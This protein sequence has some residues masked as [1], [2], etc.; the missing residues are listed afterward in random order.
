LLVVIAI[1]G[2]L[3]ALL[4]PAVQAAREAARRMSCSNNLKQLALAL[5]NYHDTFKQMPPRAIGPHRWTNATTPQANTGT[6]ELGMN[7]GTLSWT[8][9]T[10]P[11]I[12]GQSANDAITSAV[13][14]AGGQ[15]FTGPLANG[16]NPSAANMARTAAVFAKVTV[17][18]TSNFEFA[19]F[20]CPSGPR[21]TQVNA[22]GNNP[23]GYLVNNTGGPLGRLSYKACIGGNSTGTQANNNNNTCRNA[24]NQNCDG[25][26]SY[27]R[28]ANFADMTDGTSNV[29]AIGEVAM[30]FTQP[31]RFIGSIA[32]NDLNRGGV[33]NGLRDPCQGRYNLT[34]KMVT[35]PFN[36]RGAGIQSVAWAS[37]HPLFSSFASVYPPN[38]PSC[39]DVGG[40]AGTGNENQS[41]LVAASSY[42]PGG[43]QVALGDG[44]VKFFSETIDVL[45]FR[46]L[47]D[48]ADGQPAQPPD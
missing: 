26:F 3:V 6:S 36:G 34:T 12:E 10:L 9:L 2:I 35:N 47:G 20:M 27:L 17:G 11:F 39:A 22:N 7:N 25:L 18:N 23:A 37:G 8:V 42:H 32:S 29:L 5:H 4:L 33:L 13:R 15:V 46:R 16:A 38:G 19:G 21:A 44:S 30:T 1:I 24:V 31:G 45:T 14:T 48:K 40:N 28:G 41:A 43:C